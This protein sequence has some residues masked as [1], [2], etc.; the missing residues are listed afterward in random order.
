[1]RTRLRPWTQSQSPVRRTSEPSTSP[2]W[3]EWSSPQIRLRP[4]ASPGWPNRP[5]SSTASCT[6]APHQASCSG[7]YPFPRGASSFDTFMQA[8]AATTRRSAPSWA[9][10][11]TRTSIGPPH[12]G[13]RCQ[14]DRAHLRR[15]PILHQQN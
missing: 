5:P 12:R 6:S 15:V 4:D 14:R 9:K 7:A 2:G 8:C 1:V 13:R 11:S 3:S 10:H